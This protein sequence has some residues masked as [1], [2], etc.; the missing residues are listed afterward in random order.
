MMKRRY[1]HICIFSFLVEAVVFLSLLSGVKIQI[2]T[3]F[4][5][6]EVLMG[7]L[8][9]NAGSYLTSYNYYRK[10]TTSYRQ[11]AKVIVFLVI[12]LLMLILVGILLFFILIID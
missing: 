6:N 11:Q 9:F 12:N 3:T 7:V 8:A 1:I 10:E 4:L 2:E 5:I